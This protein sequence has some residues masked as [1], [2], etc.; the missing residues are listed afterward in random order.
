MS[1]RYAPVVNDRDA[2]MHAAFDDSDDD[3][4]DE[5]AETQPLNPSTHS[6]APG[7]YNFESVDYD[8]P[9]PGSPPR[10]SAVA[11]P[12]DIGN[13]NGVVPDFSRTHRP[14]LRSKWYQRVL[15]PSVTTRL[16]LAPQRPTG[17]I[18]GGINNDGVFANVTAKPSAPV[19]VQDGE[20]YH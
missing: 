13:S 20:Y 9:P 3:S 18:G 7:A 11:L 14:D 4:D 5:N 15:P 8:F 10:P 1:H 16:G 19:R 12:N 2:E 6:P 17:P